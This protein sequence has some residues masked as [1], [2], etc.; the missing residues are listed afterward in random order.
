MKKRKLHYQLVMQLSKDV[1]LLIF[2]NYEFVCKIIEE[3]KE[4]E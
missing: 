3:K 2:D 1:K 4:G